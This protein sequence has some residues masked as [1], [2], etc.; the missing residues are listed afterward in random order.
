M[1]IYKGRAL[2]YFIESVKDID[3]I[4]VGE[5]HETLFSTGKILNIRRLARR[6][7]PGVV[8]RIVCWYFDDV[9]FLR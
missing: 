3:R 7:E 5:L 9:G 8:G 2:V 1:I 6:K 4:R